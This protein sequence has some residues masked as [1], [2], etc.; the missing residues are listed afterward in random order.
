MSVELPE[1]H[2]AAKWMEAQRVMIVARN[3]ERSA[4]AQ[5]LAITGG[6]I[7][8]AADILGVSPNTIGRLVRPG[9]R[10]SGLA[11]KC[12]HRPGRPITK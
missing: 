2:P 11:P 1:E 3:L 6:N 9:G 12:S 10:L 8:Q 5:A 4:V 7:R